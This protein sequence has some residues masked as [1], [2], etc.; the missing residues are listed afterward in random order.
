MQCNLSE[1]R[2]PCN[3]CLKS[4]KGRRNLNAVAERK[5]IVIRD[6]FLAKW[7][8]EFLFFFFFFFWVVRINSSTWKELVSVR[9]S[10]FQLFS[11]LVSHTCPN[12]KRIIRGRNFLEISSKNFN[13]GLILISVDVD[14]RE[15]I[16]LTRASIFFEEKYHHR[17]RSWTSI[18]QNF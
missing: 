13:F 10:F 5:E 3:L 15:W 4:S 9:D 17:Y 12:S 16:K 1:I 11:F 8:A 6:R 14:F 2:I 18:D 7:F